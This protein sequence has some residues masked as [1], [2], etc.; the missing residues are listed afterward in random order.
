MIADMAGLAGDHPFLAACIAIG[1]FSLGGLPIFA[2]FAIKFYL[3]AAIAEAGFLWLAGLAIFSSLISL[4]YYLQV[5]R[6]MYIESAPGSATASDA[7]GHG[8]PEAAGAEIAESEAESVEDL[9]EFVGLDGLSP[10]RLTASPSFL[11]IGVLAIALA[12]VFWVG[13]YPSPLL[14]PIEAASRAILPGT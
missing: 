5:I 7:L 14:E 11:L 3:F 10:A 1:M 13:V 8:E 2:G 12:A 4:Y 6:Q 9:P